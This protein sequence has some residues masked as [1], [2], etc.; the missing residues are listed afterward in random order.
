MTKSRHAASHRKRSHSQSSGKLLVEVGKRKPVQTTCPQNTDLE[1]ARNSIITP[2]KIQVVLKKT[3]IEKYASSLVLSSPKQNKNRPSL[4]VELIP[5]PMC[6]GGVAVN[7]EFNNLSSYSTMSDTSNSFVMTDMN[8][9]DVQLDPASAARLLEEKDAE[10]EILKRLNEEKRIEI[11]ALKRKNQENWIE[12]S[13]LKMRLASFESTDSEIVFSTPP[14]RFSE[15][16]KE[17]TS[18]NE[19]S[20]KSTPT[21]EKKKRGRKPKIRNGASKKNQ[22]D[23]KDEAVVM[24]D[25]SIGS[26]GTENLTDAS[27]IDLPNSDDSS[28]DIVR[29]VR[30]GQN[31]G[32]R[33]TRFVAVKNE[34]PECKPISILPTTPDDDGR[35]LETPPISAPAILSTCFPPKR[36]ESVCKYGKFSVSKD[37][38][39]KTAFDYPQR[40]IKNPGLWQL[41]NFYKPE[42]L[43]LFP[44]HSQY[45]EIKIAPLTKIPNGS[46]NDMRIKDCQERHESF[47]SQ[48]KLRKKWA[49]NRDRQLELHEQLMKRQKVSAYD[50]LG[51]AVPEQTFVHNVDEIEQIEVS[52][53][54]PVSGFGANVSEIKCEPFSLPWFNPKKYKLPNKQRST[55]LR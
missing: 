15:F 51:I 10:I 12:I 45:R 34:P 42:E 30:D 44:M 18:D 43:T 53:F 36:D 22:L 5:N 55:R 33:G 46:D 48:E 23:I 32:Q 4:S 40:D 38:V 21:V 49:D 1:A 24:Q 50:I 7:D 47:E 37:K 31:Q 52:D 2:T 19:Q 11:E 26:D 16:A 9:N 35:Q 3:D 41:R 25:S 14:Q 27:T 39:M 17:L 8:Q 28:L 54:V 29:N 13:K 6:I 20:S